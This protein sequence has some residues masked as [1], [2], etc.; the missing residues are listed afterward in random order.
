MNRTPVGAACDCHMLHPLLPRPTPLL[1]PTGGGG[2]SRWLREYSA[3]TS[4][5][6]ASG[7]CKV[8]G[9]LTYRVAKVDP[10]SVMEI[11]AVNGFPAK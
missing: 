4:A 6:V 10:W 7:G 9:Q 3:S 2:V 1:N 5:E 11:P 8:R